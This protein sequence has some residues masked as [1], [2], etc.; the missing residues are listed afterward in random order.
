MDR[1]NFIVQSSIFG[2]SLFAANSCNLFSPSST[3]KMAYQLYS[4]RDEMERDVM[5]TL[6]ALK[7]GGYQDFEVHGL[8]PDN[9]KIYGLSPQELKMRFDDLGLSIS[10][11]H[12][13][14][15]NFLDGSKDVLLGFVDQCIQAAEVLGSE[16]LVFPWLSPTQR[17]IDY[18]KH[19]ALSLNVIGEKIK[20]AGL[21]LAY[22][23][24]DFEFT[25]QG[26]E[27]GYDILLQETDV[28]KVFFE[29]DMYWLIFESSLSPAKLI[30][31]NP[32]RITM[33]HIKDMEANTRDFTELGNGIIDYP[34]LLSAI[35]KA[36]LEHFYIE[37]DS[38]YSINSLESAMSSASYF[39][40]NLGKKI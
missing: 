31:D 8:N 13:D 28:D 16:Y 27:I 37:Q 7:V 19:L 40:K 29:L 36:G 25:E 32:G 12:Y 17:S 30:E 33:W 18:F 38:N 26:G 23:N 10:S 20:E 14:F 9:N 24:H 3:Y 11:G 4:I 39:K 5:G 15:Q 6:S 1:R 21:K 22:H 2:G 35:N 34:K